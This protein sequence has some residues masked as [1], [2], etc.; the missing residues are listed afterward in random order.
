MRVAET[1]INAA[2]LFAEASLELR[3]AAAILQAR[4]V[5]ANEEGAIREVL[6]VLYSYDKVTEEKGKLEGRFSEDD[7]A[8]VIMSCYKSFDSDADYTPTDNYFAALQRQ[9]QF[10][11][12]T[13]HST[14]STREMLE[15]MYA[16][17]QKIRDRVRP[18]LG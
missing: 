2:A 18:Y 3:A 6:S 1:A 10:G 8:D 7:W 4:S 14:P 11:S 12:T 17:D 9:S 16:A 5:L 15:E 13:G